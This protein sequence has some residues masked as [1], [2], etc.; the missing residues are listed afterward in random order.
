MP[1][2]T[3]SQVRTALVAVPHWKKK[4]PNIVRVCVFKD[5]VVAMCFVNAVARLAEKTW[6]HP[7]I[8]IRWNTVTLALCTHSAGGLTEKDFELAARMDSLARQH[9]AR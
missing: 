2:L 3:P 4:G 1:K 9:K 7:D 5:F 8:D 6:H